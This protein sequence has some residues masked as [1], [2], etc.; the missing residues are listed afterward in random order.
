MNKTKDKLRKIQLEKLIVHFLYHVH[1]EL[2][3]ELLRQELSP[4]YM[5]ILR[6]SLGMLHGKPIFHTENSNLISSSLCGYENCTK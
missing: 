1:Q 3:Q 6:I 5:G 2:S 4:T